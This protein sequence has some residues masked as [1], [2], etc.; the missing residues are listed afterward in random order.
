MSKLIYDAHRFIPLNRRI[1]EDAPLQVYYSAVF[2]SPTR[3]IIKSLFRKPLDQWIVN[4]PVVD[5]DW[6]AELMIL[7]DHKVYIKSIT[8]SLDNQTIATA[9]QDKVRVW[10]VATGIETAKF[11]IPD[12]V[13]KIALS[14][15]GQIVA[16]I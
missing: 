16:L 9:T 6:G 4:A 2:F 13:E 3:S 12:D 8:I 7:E 10:E 14:P 1:I 15:D 11:P 5:E